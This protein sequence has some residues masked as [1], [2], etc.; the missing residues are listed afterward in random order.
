M[1]RVRAAIA[2]TRYF[3]ISRTGLDRLFRIFRT[4]RRL[5]G[6]SLRTTFRLRLVDVRRAASKAGLYRLDFRSG[7]SERCADIAR[8]ARRRHPHAAV[9]ERSAGAAQGAHVASLRTR[10]FRTCRSFA[11]IRPA[12][13]RDHASGLGREPSLSLTLGRLGTFRGDSCRGLSSIISGLSTDIAALHLAERCF[14]TSAHHL[15]IRFLAEDR[16]FAAKPCRVHDRHSP[17]LV[18]VLSLFEALSD[19]EAVLAQWIA[20]S[21]AAPS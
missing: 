2:L 7:R 10:R 9:N 4:R 16:I 13:R 14:G 3:V 21:A 12:Q 17:M 11:N 19:T 8:T 20:P 18:F 5:G 6:A 1:L 15:C